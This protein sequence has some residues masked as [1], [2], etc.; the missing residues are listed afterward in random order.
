MDPL[1]QQWLEFAPKPQ[2][3][4]ASQR[5]HV[6]LSYRSVNRHW[7]L[8]LYDILRHLG[9]NVFLDQYVLS[10]A[11]PLALTLS[12][13]LDSSASAIMMWSSDFNDSSWCLKEFTTLESKEN[14]GDGFRY[15][16]AKL[17][18]SPLPALAASK[19]Y[20]DFAELSEGPGGSGLLRLLYG[21]S[22]DPLPA[23][24]IALA[25]QIDEAA[26]NDLLTIRAARAAGD[27]ATLVR[28]CSSDTVAWKSSP[29]LPCEAAEALIALGD[30]P[31]ALR[32]LADVASSFPRALRPQ[33]LTGLAMARS[34]D[35][36]AAQIVL[37]RL[38]AAG[39][40][41]PETLGIYGRTWMD[42][43]DKTKD[44]LH[45]L[46]ARDLY[47]QAFEAAPKDYYTGINAA[48][49]SLLLGERDTA[50]QLAA[51]VEKLVGT[52]AIPN[53]Y[54]RTATIAEVQLLQ[55]NYQ[56][57]AAL[58]QSAVGEAPLE[59]GSHASTW[60]AASRLLDCLEASADQET[61]IRNVF[62]PA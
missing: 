32:V 27:T 57:A 11:A 59:R 16:I 36:Q 46:R 8:Q 35:W 4:A 12:E 17:D 43:Y 18:A 34:G 62:A 37:G 31:D 13:E 39:E 19:I 55:G 42:R 14:A 7:V 40:I 47:R 52:A 60:A 54:W 49:K 21:L 50:K 48:S 20:V 45:L 6:F 44:R 9:Y 1:L 58:Y 61:L 23:G 29:A 15:V 10:A 3:L 24:A 28:L 38:Y 51:R 41:D 56:Q 33:Q 30:Y 25:E 53:D 26:Q 22:G 2:P 5:W